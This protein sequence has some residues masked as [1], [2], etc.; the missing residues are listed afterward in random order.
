MTKKP[1]ITVVKE[2]DTGVWLWELPTGGYLGTDEGQYLSMAGKE[3]DLNAIK[4]MKDAA[5]GLGFEG[6]PV[7]VAGA[8]KVTDAE[9]DLYRE[10]LENGQYGDPDDPGVYESARDQWEMKNKK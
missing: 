10:R 4:K 9:Y 1:K 6:K 2:T 7:F 8:K 5:K 3:H